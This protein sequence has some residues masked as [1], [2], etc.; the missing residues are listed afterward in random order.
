MSLPSS[1]INTLASFIQA[2]TYLEIGVE[3]GLTFRGVSI[4]KRTGVDPAF[5]FDWE[6]YA[7]NNDGVSLLNIDSDAFF[8]GGHAKGSTF[9]IVFIDGLHHYDQAFRDLQNSV[10]CGHGKTIYILDDTCPSDSFS[11]NRSQEA[12]VQLRRRYGNDSRMDWHGDTYKAIPLLALFMLMFS[13]LTVAGPFNPQTLVWKSNNPTPANP[14]CQDQ[15]LWAVNNLSA[16]DYN[17]FLENLSLYN[18]SSEDDALSAIREWA[19]S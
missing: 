11:C 8:A 16:C 19:T 1:R 9:D 14:L 15:A 2:E 18:L 7:E 17:W 3:T 5:L 13:Y 12:A 6:E 10:Q 4:P